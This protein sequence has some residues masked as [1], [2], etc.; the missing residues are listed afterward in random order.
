LTG[1][2]VTL[3]TSD[4]GMLYTWDSGRRYDRTSH[5]RLGYE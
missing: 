2:Q 4:C 1:F 5:L 3:P